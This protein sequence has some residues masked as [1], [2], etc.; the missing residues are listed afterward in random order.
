[1]R[2]GMMA[3]IWIGDTKASPTRCRIG[4]H[5]RMLRTHR[6]VAAPVRQNRD[7]HEHALL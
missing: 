4:D 2:G 6:V 7:H 3:E 5:D 1:M